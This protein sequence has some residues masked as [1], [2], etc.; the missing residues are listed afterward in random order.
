MPSS[1]KPKSV[2]PKS[3]KPSIKTKTPVRIKLTSIGSLTKFGYHP[4]R[5]P[6]V[7]HAALRKAF[8]ANGFTEVIRRLNVLYIYN[9]N[10]HPALAA[11]YRTDM[12]WVQSQRDKQ[13]N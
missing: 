11:K 2:K 6:T 8:K 10:K 7:R 4:D 9:K 12:H 3:A 13:K 1:V 5:S